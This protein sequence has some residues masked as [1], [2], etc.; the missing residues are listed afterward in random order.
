MDLIQIDRAD[1]NACINEFERCEKDADGLIR[2][3]TKHC[4]T[5]DVETNEVK[6]FPGYPY[7]IDFF[8]QNYIPH[9]EHCEKSRQML[10]SW[11]Y[12]ILFLYDIIFRMN[13]ANFITSRKEFLVDD[14]GSVS[15]PNSLMGRIR[16]VWER[17]PSFLKMPLE[18]SFLKIKNPLTNSFIIGES[19]N[20]NAGRSGTFRRALMDE[21]ALIPKSESVFSSI[22]QACKTGT[23]MNSTPFGRG[24]CFPRIKFDK[25]T[26]FRKRSFHWKLHPL[27][28]N[29]WYKQQCSNMTPDQIAREL[30]ISY[31]KSIS[32]QIYHM[33][34]FNT[35]VGNVPYDSVLPLYCGWDFGTGAPT[36][37]VWIQELP[38]PDSEFP[39]I[40]IID[41]LE[42]S[43]K[44]PPF[45]ARV[46][47]EKPYKVRGMRDIRLKP[48]EIIH[49]GDPAGK[50]REVNM[51]SW[52]SW[53]SEEDILIR[54]KHG[55][56][57]T[58][59]IQA[60]QRIMK[61]IR[62]DKK[63][64]RFLECLANYKHPT[65]D[66]GVVVSDGYEENWATHIIKAFEYYVV[67]RFPLR[68]S[69]IGAL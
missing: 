19:A 5:I 46:I 69:K 3:A 51:K 23:Y 67:N 7:L 43:E 33:F 2:F 57:I 30:D 61:N 50:S 21:A 25:E 4:K 29:L 13:W 66:Q 27:R 9:N 10:V 6:L 64:V 59:S 37:I 24:G 28:N 26:T 20:P 35:Q 54:Y 41:E 34:D 1:K 38:N 40:H 14:G 15:T 22:I 42:A 65:D 39:W 32:G 48:K 11:A 45:F 62:V 18:F 60:T 52:V 17:L 55:V 12:M 47:K 36:A 58:D 44:T 53:L 56:R 49:Y 8:R 63:C 31:E 16:F 68:K